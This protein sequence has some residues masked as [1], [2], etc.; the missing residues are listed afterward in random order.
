MHSV[1][2]KT[3]SASAP[4][5]KDVL[6]VDAYDSFSNNVISMLE[7]NLDV[8]VTVLTVDSEWPNGDMRGFLRG[9]DAVV[10]GPGPG[11]PEC[12]ADVGIMNDIW[13][14]E[15][16]DLLPVLGICLGFQS[17]CL[18]QGL[19]IKRL[20]C[21]L[22]GQV[23]QISAVD[24]DI[25]AGIQDFE[26]TLYHSLYA[27]TG[28]ETLTSPEEIL[29]SNKFPDSENLSFLAWLTVQ[30]EES[31]YRR[32]PMG[33]RHKSKPFWGFQFHP[34]SCKSDRDACKKL[35]WK[36]WAASIEFNQ[37]SKRNI[38]PISKDIS[39]RTLQAPDVQENLSHV[40]DQLTADSSQTCFH[41]SLPLHG[42][43]PENIFELFNTPGSPSVLFQSNGRFSIMS[44]PSPRSWRLEYSVPRKSFLIEE[45]GA[46]TSTTTYKNIPV[47]TLW[48]VLKHVMD[49]KKVTSGRDNVPFWGG[50]LGYFSYEMG[51]VGLSHPK[52]SPIVGSNG[53]DSSFAQEDETSVPDASLLWVERSIVIDNVL[54]TI[55]IQSTRE[56]DN[57]PGGW[58]E[59][60]YQKIQ[61][62]Y[63]RTSQAVEIGYKS[64][65]LEQYS[66]LTSAE[67]ELVDKLLQGSTVKIPDETA[68][69]SQIA[70]CQEE[71]KAGE[72]YEL[73][74]TG[75]TTITLPA[76]TDARLRKL[77]P[78]L[79][80]KKLK[81][82]NPAA[83]SAY[84]SLGKVKIASS[85]P[86]CFL[87]WDRTSTLEMKPMK[88][89]VRK[90]PGMTLEKAKE[91][92]ATT[93]EMAEN[94][95]I[96]DLIRHDL[97]GICGSGNVHVEKLL[98]VEDYGRVYSMITHVKGIV[99]RATAKDSRHDSMAAYGLTTLQR[100]LPPGSMTGAPKERSCMH[101][102]RIEGWKRGIYSGVMGY[103]DLG[104]SGSFSVLIRT[105][106]SSS[107]HEDAASATKPEV[108]RLGAG[109]A[110]TILSTP[111]GEW[112]EMI[113]KLRTVVSIF[114]SSK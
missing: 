69:K 56:A 75:E 40:L 15:G 64:A 70:E 91:I 43:Y 34:E 51:L 83:F 9:F 111:Q 22:H 68:Y 20:P 77:R 63:L 46:I 93:K 8:K 61:Q 35:L 86:E 31:V 60:I 102:D 12:A 36:W 94:L 24:M 3:P 41:R 32:L 48:Q 110:V 47:E 97:Y 18:N 82:Y 42:L 81:T 89:T 11:H 96:A 95:M 54:R 103:L 30:E 114:E 39:T 88:G 108:W 74:L 28:S 14:L 112:D 84:G 26:V 7:E 57:Q 67:R 104:G 10:L 113:T 72:S 49:T 106:F 58:L 2:G 90:S 5:K 101:L 53:E 44:L 109:G 55:Y 62:F 85:S 50:F 107:D 19:V 87:I 99:D 65:A 73:C 59:T 1:A 37:T 6:Y 71:L 80:Y 25:F 79:I 23:H 27:S 98:D 29:N 45:L 38:R 52:T 33:V 16:E 100:T 78:W 66:L 21:P 13:T 105:A 76:I 4:T 92:L 17:L